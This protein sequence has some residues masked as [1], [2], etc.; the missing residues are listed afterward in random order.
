MAVD[1]GREWEMSPILRHGENEDVTV[2]YTLET[3]SLWT[4]VKIK[5][6]FI[7]LN[8][9]RMT[10]ENTAGLIFSLFFFLQCG[11]WLI[12]GGGGIW[13]IPLCT[14]PGETGQSCEVGT[15]T[16]STGET[17]NMFF[18]RA[19]L[20]LLKC[21]LWRVCTVANVCSG[22]TP[23]SATQNATMPPLWG[24]CSECV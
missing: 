13:L 10:F 19:A 1:C 6:N 5:W 4:W 3:H 8:H 12:R 14:D 16:Y 22:T 18:T 17:I 20:M 2:L 24:V 9:S 21:E 23:L 15:G 11:W 7:D